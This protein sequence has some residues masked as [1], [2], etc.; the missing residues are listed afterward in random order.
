MNLPIYEYRCDRCGR[1]SSVLIRSISFATDAT[2]PACGSREM[3][4]LVSR[5]AVMQSEDSRL[6]ALSDPSAFSGVDENDPR[7]VARWARR[8][9]KEM[10]EDAGPEFDEMIDRMEAGEEDM[11]DLDHGMSGGFDDGGLN[12]D[13]D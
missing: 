13:F 9:G 7:S 4:K 1:R 12:S 6:D 11:G 2:C 10:G 3:R 8:M 5:F